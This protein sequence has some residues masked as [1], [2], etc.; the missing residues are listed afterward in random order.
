M[1]LN[2]TGALHY[3]PAEGL[4][5]NTDFSTLTWAEKQWA[6]WYILIE[7]PI[8]ATGLMS[9][10]LHEVGAVVYV[11]IF[12]SHHYSPMPVCLLWSRTPMDH[13]RRY[14]ILPQVETSTRQS[15]FSSRAM[16]VY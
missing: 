15:A 7:N 4:Y 11:S 3:P 1:S 6:G 12:L 5:A 10:L 16:G 14:P 8:I 13:H 2:F 9:F